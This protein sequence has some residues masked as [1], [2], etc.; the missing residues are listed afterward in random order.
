[1]RTKK[2]TINKILLIGLVFVLSMLAVA[3]AEG[4]AEFDVISDL[5]KARF[6]D[7]GKQTLEKAAN[8]SMAELEWSCSA[9]PVGYDGGIVYEATLSG[10]SEEYE[11]DISVGFTVTY[12]YTQMADDPHPYTVSVKWV[13][14]AGN[15]SEADEDLVYVIDFIYGNLQK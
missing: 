1:M 6:E 11:A 10:Y 4:K 2:N 12:E 5:K 15:Y 14:V 3:C 7:F 9:E 8:S 13:E